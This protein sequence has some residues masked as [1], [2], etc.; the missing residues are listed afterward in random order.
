MN[1][2][3]LNIISADQDTPEVD[4]QSMTEIERVAMDII[5][6]TPF[7]D[8]PDEIDDPE[9][10]MVTGPATMA[11]FKVLIEEA[12]EKAV[13]REQF[14]AIMEIIFA[15]YLKRHLELF[16]VKFTDPRPFN[17]WIKEK[18]DTVRDFFYVRETPS[19]IDLEYERICKLMIGKV[20]DF[21]T[22]VDVDV[23]IEGMPMQEEAIH[24]LD[25]IKDLEEE[26][27]ATRREYIQ[28]TQPEFWQAIVN[29][30]ETSAALYNVRN[31]AWKEQDIGND[32]EYTVK[33]KIEDLHWEEI[34]QK[35]EEIKQKLR[36]MGINP[37]NDPE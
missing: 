8:Y 3:P 35:T 16:R 11:P 14:F 2:N 26:E 30:V 19:K 13:N 25:S 23:D 29:F 15:E 10:W 9:A 37:E 7:K 5:V 31:E 28:K 21:T 4:A 6:D 34:A 20:P 27:Q 12:R 1:K 18:V 17:D 33:D 24:F 36:N 22:M 32:F